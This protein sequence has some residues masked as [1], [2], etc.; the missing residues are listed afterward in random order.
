MKKSILK[1]FIQ[2][3]FLI[4]VLP[5]IAQT[6]H[7]AYFMEGMPTRHKLNPALA[8]EYGY[9]SMPMLGDINVGASSNVGVSTFL[10][11]TGGGEIMNFLDKAVDSKEF[12][13]SLKSQ[14]KIV[15]ELDL[16]LLSFGF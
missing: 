12:L 3:I 11:P 6:T 2:V 16:S 10:Y 13:G 14:N 8:S 5:G 15:A 9:V 4:C 7:S 1:I